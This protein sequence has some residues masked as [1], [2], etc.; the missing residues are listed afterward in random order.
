MAP[1]AALL[2]GLTSCSFALAQ[3]EQDGRVPT[4]YHIHELTRDP[5]VQP[6]RMNA[7]TAFVGRH[8]ATGLPIRS[9]PDNGYVFLPLTSADYTAGVA[10]GVNEKGDA[11]GWQVGENVPGRALLWPSKG[12]VIELGT[13]LSGPQIW[14]YATGIND[15]G[16][17][18]GFVN[19][20]SR[21]DGAGKAVIWSSSGVPRFLAKP[22]GAWRMEG[23]AINNSGNVAGTL[24]F[25]NSHRFG[26]AAGFFWSP[27]TGVKVFAPA[28][29]VNDINDNDEVVGVQDGTN[30]DGQPVGYG[31]AFYWNPSMGRVPQHLPLLEGTTRCIARGI[32]PDGVIAGYCEEPKPKIRRDEYA[33]VAWDRQADGTWQVHELKLLINKNLHD[34]A[35]KIVDIDKRGR[36][37]YTVEQNFHFEIEAAGLAIPAEMKAR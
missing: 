5:E 28:T 29:Q 13:G 16:E 36:L 37:L 23:R 11:V 4:R 8:Q 19:D 17:V 27:A 6:A 26:S 33:A 35:T 25:K 21:P 7:S 1:V 34:L 18:V 2:L 32:S 12:G 9:T 14:T 24:T 15:A 20:N 10:A 3:A 30:A 31:H 22:S